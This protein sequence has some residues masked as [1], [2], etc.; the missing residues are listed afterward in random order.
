MTDFKSLL[1]SIAVA[2][3]AVLLGLLA[4]AVINGLLRRRHQ[5]RPFKVGGLPLHLQEWN[6]P[7][8]ALIPASLLRLVSPMLGFPKIVSLPLNHVLN[9]WII[10]A[11]A[12][13]AR[14][15]V[16]MARLM[17]MSRYPVDMGDNLEARR[18]QTQVQVVERVA[19]AAICVFAAAVMLMTFDEVRQFG[20]SLL[21][22]AGVA[23]IVIGFAA[24]KS[25]GTLLAG[26]QIAVSQPIRLDDVVIV[27]GEWGRI[28]E[29]TLTYVV[30]RIWDERGLV[31]PVTYFLDNVF[32]NWTRT[33]AQL[34]GT[35]FIYTD[36][37]IPV[38]RVR[39]ELKQILDGSKLWDGR[40]W[41]LQVTNSTEKTVELPALM[42]AE[43]SSKAW[44]LRCCVRERMITFLQEQFPQSLPK[45]RLERESVTG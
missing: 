7:L 35:V 20:V 13:L 8:R 27:E 6:S 37:S 5:R 21:A 18:V 28:E 25:L 33:A 23:G 34:L 17:I 39:E 15:T 12:W 10:G 22:S 1:A 45:L 29:I 30:V 2:A 4:A 11:I 9:L 16:S 32:Q 3:M 38:E 36:Y 43:D 26:I 24:Q 42:S 40:V 44:D 14:R 31:V 41:G 19:T